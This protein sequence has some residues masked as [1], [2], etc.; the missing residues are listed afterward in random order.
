MPDKGEAAMWQAYNNFHFL[1]D[2]SR[3][4][5]IFARLELVRM[6]VDLP[7]D[8]VDAGAFKGISTL[9]FAHMLET[10]Q[11][12]GRSKVI[13]F[14]TFETEVPGLRPDE[15]SAADKLMAAHEPDA[16]E[17]LC[18]TVRRFG[19]EQRA[20]IVRGDITETL[21]RY[22][23]DNPGFRIS[24]LHCD[25]D[26]YAPTLATLKTAWP[27][28]VPDGIVVFD[29]YAIERW[30]ESDAADEFFAM[31]ERPPRLRVLPNTATPTAYCVKERY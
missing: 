20:E 6:V 27:Q 23:A 26:A 2:T 7:G 12:H 24:L 29:E 9:Q 18:E 17:R 16:F 25:L 5:K 3:F 28:I 30:G 15:K 14:D 4:Q 21:P 19:L 31:L 10:Y 11:P 13:G 22:V 8:I 1:C